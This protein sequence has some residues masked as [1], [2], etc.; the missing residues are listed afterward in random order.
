MKQIPLSRILKDISTERNG[1]DYDWARVG[2]LIFIL[3]Y[4]LMGVYKLLKIPETFSFY[5]FGVGGG[6]LIAS[7]GAAIWAK[8][9]FEA[10]PEPP[11]PIQAGGGE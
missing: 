11:R 9:G 1:E 6:A 5:E 7:L 8:K 10:P 3:I 4:M 2:G